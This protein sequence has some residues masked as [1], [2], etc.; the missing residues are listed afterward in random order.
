MFQRCL[1]LVRQGTAALPRCSWSRLEQSKR[2]KKK[3]RKGKK[4][5]R[6][7]CSLWFMI[8]LLHDAGKKKKFYNAWVFVKRKEII[9][10]QPM[11]FL[12]IWSG[13]VNTAYI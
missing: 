8:K 5:I 6:G 10:H 4:R 7:M 3:E 2:R 12:V 13:S 11:I 1:L 9:S